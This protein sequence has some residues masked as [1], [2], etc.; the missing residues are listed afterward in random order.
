MHYTSCW[1]HILHSKRHS[2]VDAILVAEVIGH[3][4]VRKPILVLSIFHRYDKHGFEVYYP[5]CHI[6]RS[7]S[8]DSG[9]IKGTVPTPSQVVASGS[10]KSRQQLSRKK[11]RKLEVQSKESA[12]G[13]L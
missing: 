3:E 9:R 4:L 5:E 11:G 1:V 12:C 6:L 10:K 7:A 13:T 8:H 2:A